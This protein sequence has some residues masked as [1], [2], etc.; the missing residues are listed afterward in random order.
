[1]FA[2]G[3]LWRIPNILTIK[4]L[5]FNILLFLKCTCVTYRYFNSTF[6]IR[7]LPENFRSIA[8]SELGLFG[9]KH[10]SNV[11]LMSGN[12]RSHSAWTDV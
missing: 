7:N 4:M 9:L 5:V 12:I 6:K 1:M 8:V 3:L 10:R 11:G 2:S